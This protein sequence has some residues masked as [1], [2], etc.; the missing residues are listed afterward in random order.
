MIRTA[1]GQNFAWYDVEKPTPDD[2]EQLRRE[3]RIHPLVLRELVPQVRHPKMDHFGTHLFLVLTIP[4]LERDPEDPNYYEVRLEELDLIFGK[5]WLVSSHYR[6]I[7]VIEDLFPRAEEGE[8]EINMQ[9]ID[10]TPASIVY[11]LLSRILQDSINSL[12]IIEDRLDTAEREVFHGRERAMVRELSELRHDII[13]F[14]RALS[15]SRPVFHALDDAGPALLDADTRPYFR[16]L[17]SKMEQI[18]TVLKTLKETVEALEETNQALLSTHTNDVIRIL[19]VFTAV[20]LPPTLI[21][22]IFGMNILPDWIA[23]SPTQN[24]WLTIITMAASIVIPLLFL[25]RKRWIALK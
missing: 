6:P 13:D 25:W 24:F 14:R 17:T 7:S 10:S 21:G 1:R 8:A 5:T 15:P 9:Y 20:M 23:A 18:S 12:N 19:T 4:I 3:V 16:T 22:T 11:A 2:A